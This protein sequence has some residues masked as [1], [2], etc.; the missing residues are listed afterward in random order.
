MSDTTTNTQSKDL[1]IERVFDAPRELVWQV[2]TQAE[3]LKQWWGPESFTAPEI[4]VD[5]RVG[6][7]YLFC[8]TSPDGEN[9]WSTGVFTEIVPI[10]RFTFTDNFADEH[11]NIVDP[12]YYGM[13]EGFSDQMEVTV[14]LE[15][16]GDKT[17][18]TMTQRGIAPGAMFEG[19]HSG[20]SGSFDKLAAHLKGL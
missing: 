17:K 2:W 6:G 16:L 9:Y 20:W 11:G 1:I 7:K 4:Q 14:T 12:S 10:E 15:D 5:L 19:T 13:D 3:H 18:M 8:M